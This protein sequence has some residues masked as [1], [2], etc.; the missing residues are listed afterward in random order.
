MNKLLPVSVLV[1]SQSKKIVVEGFRVDGGR[2]K[3]VINIRYDDQCGNKHNSFSITADMY[4]DHREWGGGCIHDDIKKY[5]P[6]LA[7]L[8]KWHL[9]SS[10]G[11]M[12]YVGRTTYHATEYGPT[13]GYLYFSDKSNELDEKCMKYGK[14]SEMEKI[15]ATNPEFYSVQVKEETAKIANLQAARNC[16]IWPEATQEQLL[17]KSVLEDRLPALMVEFKDVIEELGFIY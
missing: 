12:H 6:E 1:K 14:I 5:A 4:R 17:D 8:I 7:Y 15:A 16:A 3:L 13:D 2:G 9:V 10:N 11:P